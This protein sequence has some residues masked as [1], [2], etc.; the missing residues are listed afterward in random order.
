MI[1]YEMTALMM[2]MI[3]CKRA[4]DYNGL[5]I[6]MC[7]KKTGINYL[8]TVNAVTLTAFKFVCCDFDK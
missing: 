2:K 3:K 4:C 8:R 5:L 7:Q 6:R 1:S